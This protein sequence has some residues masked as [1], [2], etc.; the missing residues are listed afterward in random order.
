MLP[1]GEL[2]KIG[3]S[4]GPRAVTPLL[5]PQDIFDNEGSERK[6]IFDIAPNRDASGSPVAV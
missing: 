3:K 5:I 6:E 1:C 4:P 2:S